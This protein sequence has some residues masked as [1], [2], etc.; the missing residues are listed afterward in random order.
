[1]TDSDSFN[2]PLA[3]DCLFSGPDRRR[4]L[5]HDAYFNTQFNARPVQVDPGQALCS[6]GDADMLVAQVGAGVVVAACD[7]ELK[8][9]AMGYVLLSAE[10]LSIFPFFDRADPVVLAEAVRPVDILIAEMKKR[11]AGKGRIKI[12]L[13]GGAALAGR[14]DDT[15]IKNAV[16]L[17]E[18]LARKGL[19]VFVDDTGGAHVRRVYYFPSTGRIVSRVLRR[20]EDTAQMQIFEKSLNSRI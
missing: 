7:P 12:R 2:F 16:F 9:G 4:V 1:M 8:I 15:G 11:G 6:D 19:S 20:E 14:E 5:D 13:A 10:V 18:Y 17:R 3:Q